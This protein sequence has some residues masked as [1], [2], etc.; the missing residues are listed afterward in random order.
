MDSTV[1]RDI[2]DAGVIVGYGGAGTIDHEAVVWPSASAKPVALSKYLG[3]NSP[4]LF[5]KESLAV[6]QAGDIVG[7][8]WDGESYGAFLAIPE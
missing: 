4:F 6:N 5:L 7:F 8:G 2:N 3:R 1:A